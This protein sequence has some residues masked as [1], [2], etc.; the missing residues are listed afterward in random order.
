MNS[1]G[2]AI[3]VA[4]VVVLMLLGIAMVVNQLL[5][6]KKWLN[7]PPPDHPPGEE[8]PRPPE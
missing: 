3:L 5:R 6:L 4:V 8:A 1:V 2:T 7:A